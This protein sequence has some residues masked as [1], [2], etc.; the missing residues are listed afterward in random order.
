MEATRTKK[1][2]RQEDPEMQNNTGQPHQ[3]PHT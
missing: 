1:Q 3:Q 2:D